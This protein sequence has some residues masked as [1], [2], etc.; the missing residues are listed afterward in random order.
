MAVSAGAI[1][2]SCL[3]HLNQHLKFIFIDILWRCIWLAGSLLALGVFAVGMAAQLGTV[4]WEGPDLGS[5][6][7]IIV[8]TALQEFWHAYGAA[9]LGEFGL[10]LL[11]LLIFWVVLEALF[12]GGSAGFWVYL[13]TALGR[14]SIL[15][16]AGAVFGILALRDD[17]GGSFLVGAV[18]MLGLWFVV[19]VLETTIRSDAVALIAEEF[20]KCLAVLGTLMATEMLLAFL[21]WGSLVAALKAASSSSAGALALAIAAVVFPFWMVLHSYLIAVRFSAIDIMRH[22]AHG[23]S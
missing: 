10:L 9:L 15:G 1:L 7:P 6:N 18:A 4:N 2:R 11:S 3:Y 14:L 22:A 8:V 17:T 5:T 19:S 16:S 20:T 12:R 21:L 23:Q 13:G